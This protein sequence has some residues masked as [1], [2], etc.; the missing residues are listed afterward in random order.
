MKS[1]HTHH[2]KA[3]GI[4]ALY[5]AAALAA[6]LTLPRIEGRLFPGLASVV[7]PSEATAIY[8]AIASGTIALTGI[9]FSL[10]FVMV[11]F[12]A[13]AYSPRMVPLIAR[14]KVI[15][16]ALGVFA[17][18]FLYAIAAI[19]GV[20]SSTSGRV[21][22]ASLCVVIALL[23][24]TMAMLIGLIQRIGLLQVSHVL[25]L[26]G[27]EGRKAIART[28]PPVESTVKVAGQADRPAVGRTQTV[29]HHGP[30]RWIHAIDV[31]GLVNVAR[32]SRAVIELVAAVGDPI[33]ES[34]PVLHVYGTGQVIDEPVL[35]N[36][37]ETG[38]ERTFEHDPAYA[39]RL[40]VDIAIRA[41]SPAVNDP[42]TA[43]Q[44][45]DQIEDL[46]IRLSALHLE[47]GAYR[48]DDGVVR[49]MVHT[50]T[51]PD[52][53]RLSLDE[54]CAC[55][56]TSVQVMR[57]MAALISDLIAVAPEE[58]RL[59]VRDWETRLQL[60][61]ARSFTTADERSEASTEDRQGLGTPR[62]RHRSPHLA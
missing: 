55:G 33:V 44:A 35:M 15:P 14:D 17:A 26:M 23:I 56:A 10:V 34:I 41:L 25:R 37:I 13:T 61:I 16:H 1:V 11:Q 28:Y 45:L 38:E 6:G 36:C 46:L 5:T 47:R 57:R 9:V 54:I 22:V 50:S 62:A 7:T 19:S 30:P 20:E 4:P 21:P 48:D 59:A 12:G 24:A 27:D 53:L 18:T 52:L 60:T 31:A 39:I 42:T 8:S 2:V 51:W 40:L 3:W 49:L 32:E 29:V 43:V 58:R